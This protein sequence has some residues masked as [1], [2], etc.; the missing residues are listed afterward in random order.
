VL[1]ILFE[2]RAHMNRDEAYEASADSSLP[3]PTLCSFDAQTGGFDVK[4]TG[5]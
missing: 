3:V 1:D 2:Q 4:Q 5:E